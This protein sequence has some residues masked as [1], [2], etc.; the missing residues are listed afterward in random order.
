MQLVNIIMFVILVAIAAVVSPIIGGFMDSAIIAQNASGTSLLL[1][2]SVVPMF[3]IGIIL[4]F[5]IM[6]YSGFS[7]PNQQM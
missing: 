3:W 6:I 7:S 5:L 4:T 1:M 2:Q